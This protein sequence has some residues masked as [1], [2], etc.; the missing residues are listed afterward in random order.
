MAKHVNVLDIRGYEVSP[1]TYLS[2][3]HDRKEQS[4][5]EEHDDLASLIRVILQVAPVQ[6]EE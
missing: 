4:D 2:S 1:L 6:D 5:A 3:K